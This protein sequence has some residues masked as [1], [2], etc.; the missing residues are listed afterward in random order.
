MHSEIVSLFQYFSI[1]VMLYTRSGKLHHNDSVKKNHPDIK[2]IK[3]S[4][5]SL[6]IIIYTIS[7]YNSLCEI[8]T[9]C[10]TLLTQP[11]CEIP[12][13]TRYT[14]KAEASEVQN[15]ILRSRDRKLSSYYYCFQF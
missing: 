12:I 14:L 5:I 11:F 3:L 7:K 2:K 6:I 8:L 15:I 10:V 1:T 13:P 9:F 4:L